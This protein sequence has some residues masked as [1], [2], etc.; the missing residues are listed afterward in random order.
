MYLEGFPEEIRKTERKN[1]SG[2]A[3]PA[4]TACADLPLL[5]F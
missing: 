4:L 3:L 1:F 2:L 5:V